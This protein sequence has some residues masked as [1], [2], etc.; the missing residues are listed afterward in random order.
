MQELCTRTTVEALQH[1]QIHVGLLHPPIAAAGV[2][3]ETLT[4]DALIVALPDHHPLAGR[5]RVQLGELRAEHFILPP[6]DIAP[7]WHDRISA[8]CRGAGVQPA[9][10]HEVESPHTAVGLVAAGM[11]VALV[12]E[13]LRQLRRPGVVYKPLDGPELQLETAVAW[14]S[15]D[16]SPLVEAFLAALRPGVGEQPGTS[17][18][19]LSSVLPGRPG[20]V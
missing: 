15:D 4:T 19:Q 16:R 5:R 1:R 14:R 8:Y 10:I 11:G 20:L 2:A 18:H 12:W 17:E 6:R 13:A 3:S 7:A 9:V